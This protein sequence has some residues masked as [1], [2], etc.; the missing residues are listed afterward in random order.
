MNKGVPLRGFEPRKFFANLSSPLVDSDPSSGWFW[1]GTPVMGPDHWRAAHLRFVERLEVA[2]MFTNN[3]AETGPNSRRQEALHR[4]SRIVWEMSPHD[5]RPPVPLRSADQKYP[6]NIDLW[7]AA[8]LSAYGRASRMGE[9]REFVSLTG[10]RLE[11]R[12]S[13]VLN[14]LALLLRLA[15]E[16]F[17][18]FLLTWQIAKDRP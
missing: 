17:A 7:V 5:E 3:E 2:E 14:T 10:D 1:H 15:P 6:H 12:T 4:L 16:L 9:V 13:E 11:W 18:F 8:C